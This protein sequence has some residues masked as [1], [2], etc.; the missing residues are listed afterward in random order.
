MV[1]TVTILIFHT[2]HIWLALDWQWLLI[3]LL[4][5]PHKVILIK[6]GNSMLN[7]L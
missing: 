2:R 7:D 5:M 3:Y 6:S 1:F 4:F